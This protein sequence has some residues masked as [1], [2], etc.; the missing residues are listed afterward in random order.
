MA[1][2]YH[3]AVWIDHREAKVFHFDRSG[4]DPA[5]IHAENPVHHIHH[6]ANEIGS[7]HAAESDAFLHDVMKALEGSQAI[8]ITGPAQ[9]KTHLVAY[10]EKHDAA[11][12]GHIAAVEAADHPSDKQIVAHARAYFKADHQQLPRSA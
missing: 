11:L 3:A 2:P 4:A 10:I 6:K 7:G 5:E 1:V 8:L 9:A 12:A